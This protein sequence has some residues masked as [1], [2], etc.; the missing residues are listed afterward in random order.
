MHCGGLIGG[1][2]N[3]DL[4]PGKYVGIYRDMLLKDVMPFWAR[5]CQAGCRLAARRLFRW[6]TVCVLSA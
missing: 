1:V 4:D 3:G 5:H 2:M 6:R